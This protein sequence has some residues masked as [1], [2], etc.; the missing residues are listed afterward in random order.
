MLAAALHAPLG[1]GGPVRGSATWDVA[2]VGAGPAGSLSA[3]EAARLGASVVLLERSIF[4]RWKVC[5][6][7]LSPGALQVLGCA[8]L[9]GLVARHGGVP[10]QRLHLRAPGSSA[11]V[12]LRGSAALS[13]AAFDAALARAAES[14]GAHF[15]EGVR[16]LSCERA[17]EERHLRVLGGGG[18]EVLRARVVI[19]ATG[20]GAGLV[21]GEERMRSAARRSR[22]GIGAVFTAPAYP[23]GAGE[24]HMAVGRRGYVGLVRVEDGTLTVAA[25]LDPQALRG[26]APAAAVNQVLAE[27]GLPALPAAAACGW[28]GTPLL[29]RTGGP[30]GAERLFR[31]G[32]AAGYV[33][34]FTGEGIT[35]GLSAGRAVAPL[36]VAAAERWRPELLE[37]WRA[38]RARSVAPAQRL[39]RAL[40][41]GLRRPA[42]VRAAVAALGVAPA[43]ARPFVARAARPPAGWRRDGEVHP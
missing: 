33:E 32:D 19:D 34:P 13:R 3:Y 17:G 12:A 28:Q 10:L 15:H 41:W 8:G 30:V 9:G 42:L 7:C 36:A 16:V 5:G 4:P 37:R 29:T 27:V 2:V 26:T 39:C 23:V 11:P 6:A 20:L 40:A 31:V 1:A 43:V 18:E 22:L 35:W 24:L 21:S 14:A 38:H 25:A